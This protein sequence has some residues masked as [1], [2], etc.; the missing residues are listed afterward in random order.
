MKQ[1]YPFFI[2][3]YKGERHILAVPS[4]KHINGLRVHLDYYHEFPENIDS[5]DVGNSVLSMIEKIKN[6]PLLSTT[7]NEVV[8][9]AIWKKATKYKSY[10]SFAK[11][12]LC[13]FLNFFEN[14][15]YVVSA[16]ERADAKGV[17]CGC[18]KKFEL[19]A[20]ATAE[21]IGQAVLDAFKAAEDFYAEQL[22][23]N[24]WQGGLLLGY[25]SF[26]S[27]NRIKPKDSFTWGN[28]TLNKSD[29]NK[30]VLEIVLPDGIISPKI[31]EVFTTF[32]KDALSKGI[33]VW[34]ITGV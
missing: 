31:K 6:S 30:K 4:A 29:Y 34:Y 25:L 3:F 2:H 8:E 14:G 18:I 20:T 23:L 13:C 24:R 32:Q 27:K 10:K 22:S 11:N 5:K 1:P 17:Y 7:K 15:D 16:Y 19:P 9:Q 21:E 28:Y 12:Y 33:E 26:Q